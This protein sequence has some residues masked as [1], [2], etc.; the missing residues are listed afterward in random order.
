MNTKLK[1]SLIS[2]ALSTSFY[3]FAQNNKTTL[4]HIERISITANR[5]ASLDTD[6]AMSVHSI[7]ADELKLDN[8][9]HIAESL[10]SVSGVLIDQL[11]GGQGHK[12]AIR[13]PM[14]TSGYY[15]FLQDNVPIQSAAFFNHNALWWSSFNSNASRI[16]VL[17]GAG[18]ALYGSGAVA[19]TI[20]VLSKPIS[21]MA[22]TDL[23]M[24]LGQASYNRISASHSQNINDN[25]GI[26]VSASHVSNTG[27]RDHTGSQRSE[28]TSRYEYKINDS[29]TLTT[30]L[31][32][33]DLEQEMAAG[34]SKELF[35]A[36][37]A[38]SGLQENVLQNDPLRKSQYIKL[39]TQWD[40][41]SDEDF[42]SVI[43]YI[44]HRTN[45]YTATWNA[46]MPKNESQVNSYGLLALANWQHQSDA[47]S[48]LGIDFEFTQGNQLSNQPIDITTT[49]YGAD[50]Y[51]KGEVY[52]DDTTDYTSLSPYFQ[53]QRAI[54]ALLEITVGARFDYAKFD[55]DNNMPIY[56]DIGHGLQS[57]ENRS[58]H[59]SHL[60]P[61]ASLNY[62]LT[63]NSSTYLRY[64][65]SFR[66]PTA[67]S[68]YHIKSSDT[69]D[70]IATIEAEVSDT[71]ELGYKNN[72]DALFIDIALFYMDVDDAIVRAYDDNGQRFLTN[73]G[74]VIHKGVEVAVNWQVT[75]H[76]DISGAYSQAKH[77]YDK[78]IIDEGRIKRGKL[79]EKN[80]SGNEMV[81]APEYLANLRL[82]Y[83]P[84]YFPGLSSMIEIQSI[85]EYWMDESNEKSYK[86][87]TIANIKLNFDVTPKLS[88]NARVLNL[89]DK[90]YAQEAQVRYGKETY[91]P[92]APRTAYLGLKYQ[93]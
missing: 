23:S 8:A 19:A 83:Q 27:W 72:L 55:F 17:K 7:N 93:W 47:N 15:L 80:L 88:L 44:R 57:L 60:S 42:Y 75:E 48:I 37:P 11:S 14:N 53:H 68:L 6:L 13:M 63:D 38:N 54:S 58:D 90:F 70:N 21:D 85:G 24:T 16:E 2:F 28:I 56:G 1:L 49:G 35:A 25:N 43:G 71:F 84:E 4:E 29:Q 87:Y 40:L 73:A 3:S 78:F 69:A 89:T 92:A 36:D 81:M 77:E 91:Q 46:N 20:N 10:N 64:A 39:S 59:F 61:K 51:N 79:V 9:Q 74:R 45:D 67:G 76:F 32:M 52:Y 62:H 50:T 5:Q 22:Q 12:T 34:L 65:N 86:G 31:V 41:F 82:R 30:S 26:R 33:S 66:L 18:T